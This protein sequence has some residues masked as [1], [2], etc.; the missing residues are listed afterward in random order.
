MPQHVLGLC[1]GSLSAAAVI[2]SHSLSELLP[3]ALETVGI[4]FRVGLQTLEASRHLS[5]GS[6]D[7]ESW[8]W[9][10]QGLEFLPAKLALEDFNRDTPLSSLHQPY[11]SAVGPNT[12]TISGPPYVLRKLEAYSKTFSSVV[13]LPLQVHAP[14]HAK[15]IH[16]RVQAEKLVSGYKSST[17]EILQHPLNS[18][19]SFFTSSGGK[20][21][22]ETL[23]ELLT[24]VVNDALKETIRWDLILKALSTDV[25]ALKLPHANVLA[26]GPS[27]AAGNL[28][29]TLN[30]VVEGG[31]NLHDTVSWS[32]SHDSSKQN[33][34]N[35]RGSKIA[36]VGLAGRF[37]GGANP[38]EFWKVLENGLDVCKEVCISI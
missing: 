28:A 25:E 1:I 29:T 16:E 36:I 4:A 8:S 12:L 11:I 5:P 18:S 15:R 27:K 33:D 3:L 9:V 23:L 35:G 26:L 2:A 32:A 17:I 30:N 22:A 37:P 20:Y 38:E 34:A 24:Q 13:R 21:Q 10:F 31:V 14:Y 6:S 7:I 19:T